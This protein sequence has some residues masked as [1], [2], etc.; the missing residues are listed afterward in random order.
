MTWA[1][2]GLGST[3]VAISLA[4]SMPEGLWEGR[5]AVSVSRGRTVPGRRRAG[6]VPRGQRRTSDKVHS[7]SLARAFL[8]PKPSARAGLPGSCLRL[9]EPGLAHGGTPL[10]E[11][12][13]GAKQ[14]AGP[15]N[16][17]GPASLLGSV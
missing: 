3:Y 15:G 9:G 1:L 5:A 6:R 12:S 13:V 17:M 4:V 16:R 2:P 14:G 11:G 7:Q 8:P 10:G